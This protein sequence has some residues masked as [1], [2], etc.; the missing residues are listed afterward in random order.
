MSERER[1]IVYPLLFLALGAALRDK[2]LKQ[3]QTDNIAC[4]QIFIR[5][6]AGKVTGVLNSSGLQTPAIKATLVDA[7]R[8][9]QAGR[10]VSAGKKSGTVSLP[11]GTPLGQML[12]RAIQGGGAPAPALNKPA[13][14]QPNGASPTPPP[15]IT[16]PGQPPK[17]AIEPPVPTEPSTEPDDS[18]PSEPKPNEPKPS[19]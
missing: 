3:T 16:I 9:Q 2:L 17:P 15:T 4:K 1:W 6:D 10:P 13:V 14:S 12:L 19:E 5:D 18:K 7:Q 11:L 8:L